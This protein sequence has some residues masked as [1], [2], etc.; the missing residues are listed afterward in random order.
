MINQLTLLL[1]ISIGLNGF[2]NLSINS[3]MFELGVEVTY[4]QV[5]EAT[6]SGFINVLI[7]V[8]QFIFIMI[9]TPILDAKDKQAVLI[10]MGILIGITLL[11]VLM[12]VVAPFDYKR[13]KH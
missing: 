4:Q 5:G 3:V 9:L 11:G 1:Y 2:A 6:S 12:T 7:N 8:F 13:A 10:S